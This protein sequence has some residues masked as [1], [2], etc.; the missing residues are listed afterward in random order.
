MRKLIFALCLPLLAFAQT[1]V[2]KVGGGN[3]TISNG[4]VTVGSGNTLTIASGATIVAASGST[5]TGFGGAGGSPGGSNTQV[6]FND[7]GNFGG[8]S[9]F[10]FNKTTGA[11]DITG[12]LTA[13]SIGTA[14]LAVPSASDFN[15][16][17]GGKTPITVKYQSAGGGYANIG[18]YNSS[19]NPSLMLDIGMNGTP[20][21]GYGGMR[22]QSF[23]DP[24]SGAGLEIGYDGA[25]GFLQAK[26]RDTVTNMPLVMNYD[27]ANFL[28]ALA[29]N[30]PG[31]TR[32]YDAN[33]NGGSGASSYTG[34]Y[35]GALGVAY[36]FWIKGTLGIKNG[37]TI[38]DTTD[39]TAYNV[40]S[41]LSLGGGSVAKTFNAGFNS[42]NTTP[43]AWG[44]T[45]VNVNDAAGG[46]FAPHFGGVSPGYLQADSSTSLLLTTRSGVLM[47]LYNSS[48]KG[49]TLAT[50]TGDI[51]F[52]STTSG[53][54]PTAGAV[55]ATS[56]AASENIWGGGNITIGDGTAASN[57]A[58]LNSLGGAGQGG[59][60]G[61]K[62]AGTLKS[63]VGPKAV[64]TGSGTDQSL[65]INSFADDMYLGV[66]SGKGYNFLVNSATKATLTASTL[67]LASGVDIAVGGNA[68]VSG[69]A[70]VTSAQFTSNVTTGT[71]PF[72]VASTTQVA[73]LNAATAGSATTATTATNATNTAITDDT[74]TSATMYPTWV[75]TTTGNLPQKVSSTKMTFNP[76]TGTL[77]ATVFSGAGTSLTGT[78][79]SLTAG[80][81]NAVAVGNL[82]GAGTGVLTALGVNTG[83]AGAFQVNNASGA[84]LTSLTAA[85]ISTG[86]LANGMTA[87]T[88]TAGDSSTKL[89]TTAFVLTAVTQGAAKEAVKYASTAA[90]P[91]IVY[92]NGSSGVGATL[93]G[94]ALAAISLDSSSPSVAD[95]VEIKNQVSTFQNGIYTVTATGSGAAVFVLTRATDFD[96]SSKI[97]TGASV[98][99]TA[100]TTQAN[101]TW[102][103]NSADAP[104]MGTDAITFA[105]SAGPG[106]VTAGNG[107][108][109][110]GASVAIDTSITV[111]KT[112]AQTLTTKTLT[113]P[114]INGATS[115]GSTSLDFSGNSGTFK[116]STGANTMGGAVTIADATTPSLTTASGKTNTGNLTVSGK[117]SGTFV[118]TTADA[119]AQ[120]VTLKPAAQTSGATI[121]TIPD[122]AGANGTLSF[123]D[124]AE[125]ITAVKTFSTAAVLGSST[126]TTQGVGSSNTTV[127]TTA[128]A[129]TAALA[130]HL[131]TFASPNTA[132]GAVTWTSPVYNIYTSAASTRT[133]TLPA[134]STYVNRGFLIFVAVGTG[135]VN[136]QP[137]SG[138]ALVLAG[139][140]LT[141]DHYAQLATSAPG[142]YIGWVS[143]GTNWTSLGSSGTWADAASP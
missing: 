118:I 126:A 87:T 89:A 20:S 123:I 51:V 96:Q 140:L 128:Y 56:F 95:R 94:V 44:V 133:Y 85:N 30:T 1:A 93:T 132:A 97:E 48:N 91:S 121:L 24:T 110:T 54:S 83:S 47:K 108:A 105:Q 45:A 86:A 124:K 137:A 103:V 71:A 74:T 42:T 55:K 60:F 21:N 33:P 112:T 66:A 57:I 59:Y 116:T 107:I 14:T 52:N 114:V 117:T 13:T 75:T 39:S 70:G 88:Q 120:S 40:G 11:T 109:V 78:A 68:T 35:T 79:A 76:S 113:S 139:V 46:L 136:V 84:A 26:I 32:Y 81:A 80:V 100:G 134:A 65:Y 2:Q 16:T 99:V 37:F 19:P 142:N 122:M 53:T 34:T 101:T 143:D 72:V 5:V 104:V 49:M 125:T 82:T 127:S 129:D 135:H 58:I 111:D 63:A 90:L 29:A 12:P 25:A 36:K 22:V 61:I 50:S 115:S 3:N 31:Q 131:G 138:A 98:F 102:V 77:A 8:N 130:T 23:V 4:P 119:T 10:V 27:G 64:I 38:E 141:A 18:I 69:S 62:S 67:T 17:A 92:A 6:Q 9:K 43:T 7:S 28:V 73:N 41:L 106:S 15:L